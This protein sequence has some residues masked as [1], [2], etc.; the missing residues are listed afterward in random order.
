MT[1]QDDSFLDD[2]FAD[3]RKADVD[4]S[5]QLTARV[6]T[7]AAMTRLPAPPSV[8]FWAGLREAV[9][10]WPAIGGVACAG[11]AGLWVGLAPPSSVETLAAD[12]FGT[13]T[14]VSFIGDFDD[15]VEGTVTDG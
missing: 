3:V 7:D 14:S 8:S 12:M 1:D 15:F 13:T 11:V 6:L 10:G 9:G 5:P 4:V 2:I